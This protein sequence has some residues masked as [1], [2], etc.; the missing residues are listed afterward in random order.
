MA[1]KDTLETFLRSVPTN[2]EYQVK[3]TLRRSIAEDEDCFLCR[4]EWRGLSFSDAVC[5]Q[6]AKEL[7][8]ACDQTGLAGTF[9]VEFD[10]S[11][12]EKPVSLQGDIDGICH[13]LEYAV[14]HINADRPLDDIAKQ[15]LQNA[16]IQAK[17]HY[18]GEIESA[19]DLTAEA[20]D[21]YSNVTFKVDD[22]PIR[23]GQ[24]MRV[25]VKLADGG[26]L[27]VVLSHEG[28]IMDFWD[29]EAG[30]T[31]EAVFTSSIMYDEQ[32]TV[33]IRNGL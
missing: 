9:K 13:A 8:L 6:V 19:A 30:E 10:D 12:A 17:R 11:P 20:N 14:A 5:R 1:N 31:D 15:Q 2:D 4:P 23:V 29:D 27:I 26:S 16:Y 21:P 33:L 25:E 3:I 32:A 28:I 24:D 7:Q 18:K 22:V